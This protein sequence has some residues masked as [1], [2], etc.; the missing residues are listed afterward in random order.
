[1]IQWWETCASTNTLSIPTH[2]ARCG[3][4]SIITDGVVCLDGV[5][6]YTSGWVAGAS[7]VALVQCSTVTH[8]PIYKEAWQK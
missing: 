1:M 5:T 7:N 6:A 3:G 4:I 8:T 2:I